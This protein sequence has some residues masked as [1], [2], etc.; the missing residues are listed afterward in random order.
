[1]IEVKNLRKFY[2]Q[3]AVVDGLSLTIKKG[4]VFGFL[5]QN[6]AGETTTIKM[7]VGVA[8][9]D[10]GSISIGGK[11]SSDLSMRE[12]IGFMPEAPYFYDRLS[13]L[14]FLEFCGALFERHKS[15]SGYA[16]V[17][18]QVGIYDARDR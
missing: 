11:D 15:K 1:M 16:D 18:K 14:E 2:G 7:M 9:P 13:G 5:G 6:G 3:R 8:S 10:E 4:N 12:N 17:L